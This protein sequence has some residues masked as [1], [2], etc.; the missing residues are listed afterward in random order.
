MRTQRTSKFLLSSLFAILLSGGLGYAA[1]E[2]PIVDAA[3]RADGA[4]VRALIAKRANVNEPSRDGSTALLWAAYHSDL[5]MTRALHRRRRE[6]QPREPLRHHAAAAGEP[7]R[8]HADRAGPAQGRRRSGARA[9]RGRDAADGRRVRGQPDVRAAAA[10]S[11]A[12]VNAVDTYQ[13]QTALMWAA[14]EGHADVVK[15][16]LDG[17]GGSESQGARDRDG[18]TQE[19]R[20][21][22]RRLHRA[23]VRGAQRTRG[24]VRA[25]VK[26]GADLEADQR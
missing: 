5:A 18:R 22:D 3:R 25:L 21:R 4:T 10:R 11:G 9:S 2:S 6:R 15:A 13:K 12:D 26:G 7:H 1:G 17:Q 23:D 19:R 14:A 16:L 20:S 8:R 24:R